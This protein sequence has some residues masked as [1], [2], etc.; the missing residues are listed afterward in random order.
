MLIFNADDYGSNTLNNNRILELSKH[1]IIKSFTIISNIT[2]STDLKKIKFS[3]LSTGVHINLVEGKPLSECPT[4][5]NNDG[6]FFKKSQF[7]S[8]LFL[9]KINPKEVEK[10]ISTQI[11]H[12]LDHGIIIT[13]IDSHQNMHLFLPILK[14]IKKV[15]NKYKITKIRGQ[16]FECDWF[17]N[18]KSIKPFI[19]SLY[20]W[21]WCQSAKNHFKFPHKTIIN[22]PGFGLIVNSVDNA[23]KMWRDAVLSHYNKNIIY[24][25]PCH[26]SLSDIEYE[27]YKSTVFLDLLK[28]LRIKIGSY[29]DL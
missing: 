20:S 28:E 18:N 16:L 25:V 7:V 21:F 2:T 11:E 17:A 9:G 10:E 13:H 27:L 8:K 19:R 3:G 22:A 15:A 1:E 4:L 24:E 6:N 29:N 5:V 26:L 14:I 23:I 12:I